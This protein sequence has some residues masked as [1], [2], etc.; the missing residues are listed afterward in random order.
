[1]IHRTDGETGG[2]RK[3]EKPR[4]IQIAVMNIRTDDFVCFPNSFTILDLKSVLSAFPAL[5]LLARTSTST[6][7]PLQ[8]VVL[9]SESHCGLTVVA[10]AGLNSCVDQAGMNT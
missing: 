7:G 2:M 1:M 6:P 3:G 10:S 8:L 5:G 9:F 4:Q